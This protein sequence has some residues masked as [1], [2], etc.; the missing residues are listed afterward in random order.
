[1]VPLLQV[2]SSLFSHQVIMEVWLFRIGPFWLHIIF[3]VFQI[4]M[5]GVCLVMASFLLVLN[6]LYLNTWPLLPCPTN[7]GPPEPLHYHLILP[8]KLCCSILFLHVL[9]ILP[10]SF[11]IHL[12]LTVFY[13]EISYLHIFCTL[14]IL[15]FLTI[16]LFLIF[17]LI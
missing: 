11:V 16:K 14:L 12:L 8:L 13:A 10:G 2:L 17:L 6:F 4:C 3:P 5:S 9:F 1:M 7:M 15:I